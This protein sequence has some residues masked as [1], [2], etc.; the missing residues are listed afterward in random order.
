M[1]VQ[2]DRPVRLWGW[3]DAGET[4]T[5]SCLDRTAGTLAN[6]EGRWV[7]ELP[8]IP[9]GGPYTITI[10]T[11]KESLVLNDILSGEVWVCSGQSN[12]EWITANVNNAQAELAA[13]DYPAIRLFNVVPR[14]KP[15]A[16]PQDDLDADWVACTP[17]TVGDF[18]AVGYFFGREIHTTQK[19][20]VGLINSSW[21][22][23][24][25]EVWT[26]W[27]FLQDKAIYSTITEPYLK[28]QGDDD[29]ERVRTRRQLEHWQKVMNWKDPGNRGYL[30]GWAEPNFDDSAWGEYFVPGMWQT[31]G[32]K[33]NG[34]V[35]FRRK[36]T[37]PS[38]WAGKD[39]LI[40]LGAL[41][42]F[43]VTYFNGVEIG[44]TGEETTGW[45]MHP[46][47]YTIPASL[48]KAGETNTITV[49]IFDW[50]GNGGFAGGESLAIHNGSE[51]LPIDGPWCHKV[52]YAFDLD[53][54]PSIARL[55]NTGAPN[56][57]RAPSNLYNGMIAPLVNFPI[58]G[59]LWYQGESNADRYEQYAQL[60]PDLIRSWR[61]AW[62][63]PDMPFYYVQLANWMA[64]QTDPSEEGWANIREAQDAAL[65]LPNTAVAVAID[66][67]D[68]NDIHPRDKQSVGH[69]LAV[70]ARAHIHGEKIEWSG[71]V[72]EKFTVEGTK[73]RIHFTHAKG[74]TTNDGT[75]P[76]G[77]VIRGANTGWHFAT[78]QLDGET[79]LAWHDKVEKPTTIRYAWA[80]NPAVNL[81]N[82]DNLPA[83]P[84][85]TD[86]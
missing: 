43:D 52:E 40:T 16:A 11:G 5:A 61:A 51:S 23:T 54:P 85:R 66:V 59:A 48:I 15:A 42:D 31:R 75:P 81:Y 9:A 84:F 14:R 80:N 22:G 47:R 35:W 36:I 68:A 73:A 64:P 19:V 6:T 71:P 74:L 25:A 82:S 60:F 45:W 33:F 3:A 8:A 34:A 26:E 4:V 72:F 49:R 27:S 21:G 67:G 28:L 83:R 41:D 2:H 46:R 18:S 65:Q 44:S 24:T 56:T 63:Q 78:T 10:T 77:F 17:K 69:R 38:T 70:A 7:L 86:K 58:R 50:F 55:M 79:V 53:V 13:A 32:M 1:V 37:I 30:Y 12:M 62:K 76:K 57:E 29:A 20:P 39:L